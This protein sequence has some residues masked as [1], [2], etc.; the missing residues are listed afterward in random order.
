MTNAKRRPVRSGADH[1]GCGQQSYQNQSQVATESVP[2][3]I[4]RHL[5]DD[6]LGGAGW[7]RNL[8]IAAANW[9]ADRRAA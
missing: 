5:R 1:F 2:P 9:L 7:C 8:A 3:I 4:A 6:D